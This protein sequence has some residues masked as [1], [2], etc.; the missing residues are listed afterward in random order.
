MY[1]QR[2]RPA[3][4]ITPEMIEAGALALADYDPQSEPLSAAVRRIYIAMYLGAGR[5][6]KPASCKSV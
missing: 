5:P 6:S 2:D 1:E 4:E 3:I